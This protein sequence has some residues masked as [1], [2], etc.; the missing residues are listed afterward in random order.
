[1]TPAAAVEIQTL[2]ERAERLSKG[3][4][5]ERTQASVL[6]SRISNIRAIGQSTLEI[7]RLYVQG[8]TEEAEAELRGCQ[9]DPA[10]YRDKFAEYALRGDHS[11]LRDFLAGGQALGYTLGI[12]G[13]YVVPQ[14]FDDI[15]R[16]AQRAVA[17]LLDPD[18]TDYRMN[19]G[20]NCNPV[21]IPSFD[22]ST[23]QG[24]VIT[25]TTTQS[26]QTI[27]ASYASLMNSVTIRCFL[28]SSIEAEQDFDSYT[29]RLVFAGT[30]ALLRSA[31]LQVLSGSG[32]GGNLSGVATKGLTATLTNSVGGAGKLALGDLTNLRYE[33]DAYW[34]STKRCFLALPDAC[35]KMLAAAVDGNG[36]PLVSVEGGKDTLFGKPILTCPEL[37]AA[38]CGVGSVGAILFGSGDGIIIRC[39]RPTMQVIR[40]SA[41][42][43][44][45]KGEL[46]YVFRL[47]LQSTYFDASASNANPPLTMMAV[48]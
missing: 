15:I 24:Q 13:G 44:V 33:I 32:T 16:A 1:M 39:G 26:P 9:I 34:R 46:G 4:A 2:S 10:A 29:E 21:T 19:A 43:D 40:Q 42:V 41:Q 45:T 25:E 31:M 20:P 5:S 12:E 22:L 7:Q 28:G 48:S 36:R 8:I 37:S 17:P 11:E 35:G 3:T 14:L 18:L 38:N 6:L 47:R 23:I 27:P 30:T